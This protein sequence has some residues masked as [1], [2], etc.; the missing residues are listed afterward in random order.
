MFLF[1]LSMLESYDMLKKESPRLAANGFI[2]CLSALSIKNGRVRLQYIIS[3]QPVLHVKYQLF[4]LN[5]ESCF[6]QY[7]IF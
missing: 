1:D 5:I 6:V 2:Q 4:W 3:R 7:W